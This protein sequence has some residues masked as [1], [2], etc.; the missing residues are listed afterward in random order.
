MADKKISELTAT[1][2]VDNDDLFAI[3]DG[4]VA[5]TKKITGA[6][7]RSEIGQHVWSD[8]GT[9][10]T[11]TNAGRN[12]DFGTGILKDND[13]TT[14]VSLADASNTAINNSL[15]GDASL[16]AALNTNSVSQFGE[17]NTGLNAWGSGTNFISSAAPNKTTINL[18]RGGTGFINGESITFT[19]ATGLTITQDSTS[20]LYVNSAG[21][22]APIVYS[23]VT[24]AT[25]QNSFT[26]FGFFNYEDEGTSYRTYQFKADYRYSYNTASS[27]IEKNAINP[28]LGGT[29]IVSRVGTG[30]GVSADDRRWFVSIGDVIYYRGLTSSILASSPYSLYMMYDTV[31]DGSGTW[32][33]HFVGSEL[34]IVYNNA[35]TPTTATNDKYIVYPVYVSPDGYDSPNPRFFAVMNNTQYDS[36][37]DARDAIRN[38]TYQEPTLAFAAIPH[39]ECFYIIM[40][41]NVSGGYIYEIID[42][43]GCLNTNY[44]SDMRAKENL[45]YAEIQELRLSTASP[46]FEYYLS[47]TASG[48]GAYDYM[49]AQAT[50]E[51]QSTAAASITGAGILIKGFITE[52]AEPTF[53]TLSA[54]LGSLHIHAAKTAGTKGAIIYGELWSRTHPGGVE[55]LVATTESSTLLTASS[56]PYDLHWNILSDVTINSTDRLVYKI[57]GTQSGS[58]TTPTVTIYMEGTA[59]SHIA[60]ST[61]LQAYDDRYLVKPGI[62]GGQTVYGGTG[63]ADNLTFY[64]TSDATKGTYFFP[65]GIMSVGGATLY[66][67]WE[68]ITTATYNAKSVTSLRTII[69]NT[70]G[71]DITINGLANGVLGQEVLIYKSNAA[72]NLII[73]HQNGAGTQKFTTYTGESLIFTGYEGVHCWFDGNNWIVIG[74]RSYTATI[75]LTAGT[76]DAE[77]VTGIRTI[78]CDTTAGNITI[79]GLANGIDGQEIIIFKRLVTNSLIINNN[80]GAG[81][82]KILTGPN[83]NLTLAN[84]G[85]VL[86]R[87][88]GTNNLWYVINP[89]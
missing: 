21:T 42:A 86:V 11:P 9:D 32:K 37:Q 58:G 88:L 48:V 19:T 40:L 67:S 55:T 15:D 68:I 28:K 5:E 35:G 27:L 44:I 66:I 63:A 22:V 64:T 18:L 49:Y 54:G 59:N 43:K 30:T 23:S 60:V 85:G 7:M 36:L 24:D 75:T 12:V 84:H 41:Q 16:L 73:N 3:V 72:N 79:R 87:F 45:N 34:P 62:A 14:G 1:T 69:C 74:P 57:Y 13:A 2:T 56:T 51:A 50:G 81:T 4:A 46:S 71:G 52:T 76:Y 20:Y 8:D 25:F 80:D 53:T 78:V 65:E 29:L 82:E 61:T 26:L 47:D 89:N 70:S 39:V 6:D 33:R 77:D 31:G 10:L 83:A 17:K 38:E